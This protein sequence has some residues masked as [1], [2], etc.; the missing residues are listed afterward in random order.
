MTLC[1]IALAATC[2]KCPAVSFCPLKTSLGDY[3][4]SGSDA[5]KAGETQKKNSSRSRHSLG[6]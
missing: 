4:K 3:P 2:K 6:R 1:P 5:G